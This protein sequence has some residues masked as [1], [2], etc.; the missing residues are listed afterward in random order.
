MVSS[1]ERSVD[2]YLASLPAER[3]AVVSAVR[4]V[5]RQNLPEGYRETMDYGMI[6]Y[7]IPPER[8]GDPPLEAI[9]E[10]IAATT[11]EQFIARHEEV[12]A[13]PRQAPVRQTIA[14]KKVAT[15]KS[16]SRKRV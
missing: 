15:K 12:R 5:V 2:G 4:D 14:A 3:R 1:V 7:A 10:F 6:A 16:V 11:P 9:G 13:A 8:Y